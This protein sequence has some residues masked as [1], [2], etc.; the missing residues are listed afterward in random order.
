NRVWHGPTHALTASADR[1]D[2]ILT[3]KAE[4]VKVGRD[5]VLELA[6]ADVAGAARYA[7]AGHDGARC[8]MLRDRPDLRAPPRPAGGRHGRAERGDW[9]FLV[10]AS[11]ERDALLAR[12]QV[13]VVRGLLEHAGHGDTFAVL[14]ANNRARVL[15]PKPLAVTPA[16]VRNVLAALEKTQRIG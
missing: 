11:A 15:T 1:A 2:L 14:V 5:V 12:T 7:S 10:E 16:N 9:V 3:T 13:E 8:L 4:R 6:G